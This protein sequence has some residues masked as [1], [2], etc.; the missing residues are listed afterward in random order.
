MSSFPNFLPRGKHA[1]PS[2]E[3]TMMRGDMIIALVRDI[4]QNPR[5]VGEMGY[6]PQYP[7]VESGAWYVFIDGRWQK[8][9]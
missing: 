6:C 1:Q 3:G 9:A 8:Q 7:E 4:R 2:I 5:A